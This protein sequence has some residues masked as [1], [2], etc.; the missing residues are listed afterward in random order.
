MS[1][2][3]TD[4]CFRPGHIYPLET[5]AEMLQVSHEWVKKNMVYDGSCGHFKKGNVY[6]FRGEWL[7]NWCSTDYILP[8]C[9]EG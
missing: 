9:D 1:S 8:K 7:V 6:L 2:K 3:I 4:N 5:V